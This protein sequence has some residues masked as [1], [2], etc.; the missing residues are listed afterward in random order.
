MIA[1]GDEAGRDVGVSLYDH[2]AVETLALAQAA[3]RFGLSG[4]WLGEHVVVPMEMSADHPYRPDDDPPILGPAA[5]LI[6]LWTLIGAISARTTR[7]VIATG[8]YLLP[9]RSPVLTALAAITAQRLSGGRLLLGVGSGWLPEEYAAVGMSFTDRGALLD[10]YIDVVRA[11]AA[12]GRFEH[13][14]P[15]IEVDPIQISPD[16][17]ELPIVIGGVS[18]P[19]LKRAALRGDGWYS[20]S[21]TTLDECAVTRDR[22][23]ALRREYD[24]TAR[25]F[26]YYIRIAGIPDRAT[27]ARYHEAGFTKLSV[28]GLELWPRSL[29]LPLAAKLERLEQLAGD[30]ALV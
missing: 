6:D 28:S 10:E 12:G 5:Q 8:V 15:H 26:T 16:A 18:D 4:V 17:V 1:P 25:P 21:T 22:I 7:L 9:L 20:P 23:E 13:H 14:S 2:G 11:A 24:T 29:A 19:A 3:E 27:L 30:L